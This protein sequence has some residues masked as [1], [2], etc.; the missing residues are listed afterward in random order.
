L[1]S[2]R[3]QCR[4]LRSTTCTF[5][6]GKSAQATL[7]KMATRQLKCSSCTSIC[8]PQL[9]RTGANHKQHQKQQT[10]PAQAHCVEKS[11]NETQKPSIPLPTG[12]PAHNELLPQQP[13]RRQ[14]IPSSNSPAKNICYWR[15]QAATAQPAT[16]RT[17]FGQPSQKKDANAHLPPNWKI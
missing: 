4:D 11:L 12:C 3:L 13:S 8:A 10:E 16:D 5:S 14:I 15:A 1:C 6:T 2:C 7:T 9:V 17:K